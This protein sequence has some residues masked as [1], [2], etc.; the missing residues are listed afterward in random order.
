MVHKEVSLILQLLVKVIV[1]KVKK[2]HKEVVVLGV[3]KSRRLNLKDKS[4]E[5]SSNI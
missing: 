4:K 2:V 3:G 1:I 5:N